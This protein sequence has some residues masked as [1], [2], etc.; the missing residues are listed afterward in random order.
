M[1][2][3]VKNA[4]IARELN[5]LEKIV[6]KKP[7]IQ[8]LANVLIKAQEGT[9]ILCATDLE[10]GLVG[11]CAAQVDEP[12]SIT[13]PA[14]KLVEI[15]RAQTDPELRLESDTRGAVQFTSGKF[16][17]RL[18]SLPATDFPGIPSINGHPSMTLPR[19]PL[20]SMLQQVR[21]AMSDKDQR[22]Y[23]RGAYMAL[24]EGQLLLAATDMARLSLTEVPREGEPWESTLVPD[25]AVDE[26]IALLSEDG[27][28]DVTFVRSDR[29]LF[30]V[31]E[32]RLLISRQV[33]GKFPNYERIIP[34]NNQHVATIDRESFVAVLRRLI[35]IDEVVVLHLTEDALDCTAASA[36]VGDG[37]EAVPVNYSGPEMTLRFKGI[38]ILDFLTAAIGQNVTMELAGADRPALL[39]DGQ[40]INIVMGMR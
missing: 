12:G 23:M 35:L 14:K 28:T 19:A 7:T 22:Y 29:H 37:A 16:K 26:L 20:K 9:I 31:V 13:L 11:A 5:H 39:R 2:V 33:D 38:Y 6:G 40:F 27:Q 32:G 15:V 30:F 10:I 21:Y 25:K 4:D 8:V 3:T 34:H 1:K 36:E 18:Q 17:S 24:P